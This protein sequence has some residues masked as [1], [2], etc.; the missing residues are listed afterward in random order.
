M[1][2]WASAHIHGTDLVRI[3]V[4][5]GNR[6]HLVHMRISKIQAFLDAV[7]REHTRVSVAGLTPDLQP[8]AAH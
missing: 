5:Y 2:E 7:Q 8:P 1:S 3:N 4:Q 6:I